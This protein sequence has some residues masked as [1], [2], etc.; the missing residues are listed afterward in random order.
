MRKY[1]QQKNDKEVFYG[2]RILLFTTTNISLKAER[3]ATRRA[4][5]S[6]GKKATAAISTQ[7]EL[8]V[9]YNK[10]LISE[11]FQ[12]KK[13]ASYNEI[14]VDEAGYVVVEKKNALVELG[15]AKATNMTEPHLLKVAN[16]SDR[17]Q[18]CYVLLC[19]VNGED[20]KIFIN[21]S[22]LTDRAYIGRKLAS[23]GIVLYGKAKGLLPELF[24]FL[25]SEMR[26]ED[27]VLVSELPGWFMSLKKRLGFA[28]EDD[29]TWKKA[30]ALC[31]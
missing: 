2:S 22:K 24:A 15:P 5:A 27:E 26:D 6:G 10:R 11:R 20:Q 9:F 16:A 23:V 3:E 28:K 7:K 30:R 14:K 12:E 25:I 8:D 31:R 21:A 19:K 18:F 29:I 1:R 17:D 13:A 4:D